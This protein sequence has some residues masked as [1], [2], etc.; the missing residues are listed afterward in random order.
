[1]ARRGKARKKFKHEEHEEESRNQD[2][3]DNTAAKSNHPR[4]GKKSIDRYASLSFFFVRFVLFVFNFFL[5]YLLTFSAPLICRFEMAVFAA[6]NSRCSLK[7]PACASIN[8]LCWSATVACR[9]KMRAST[10]S[11]ISMYGE[12]A[13]R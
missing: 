4:D 1:V 2:K 11:R 3:P 8:C 12:S 9:S 7:I 10:P 13:P 5:A 6:I